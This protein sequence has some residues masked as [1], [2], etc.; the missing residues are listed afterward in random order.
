MWITEATGWH[1]DNGVRFRELA[2]ATN[3]THLPPVT[4]Q[5]GDGNNHC[6]AY[7]NP[8]TLTEIESTDRIGKGRFQHGLQRAVFQASNGTR[9]LFF[10]THLSFS[11]ETALMQEVG[12]M[13]DYG[14][15]FGPYPAE[16]VTLMDAN[17][18]DDSDGEPDWN[19]MP[20]NLWHRYRSVQKDGTFGPA[21]RK[22][23]RTLLISGWRDPQKD[24]AELRE[25]TT[26]FFY[27]NEKVP[28]R[29]DQ[30]LYT[31]PKISVMDYRT[32]DTGM[33]SDHKAVWLV[34]TLDSP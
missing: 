25:P 7:Y 29:I 11:G 14:K 24:V 13:A 23:R 26:G 31:G 9:F 32:L 8:R 19:A 4:S 5:V 15:Q 30:A 16:A 10:G 28:L 33:M 27:E 22:A 17:F 18:L 21:D 3:M 12:Y 34:F 20:S 1:R 2:H 6:V